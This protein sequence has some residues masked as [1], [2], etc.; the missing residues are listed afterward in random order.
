MKKVF[1]VIFEVGNEQKVTCETH[2][3]G[4]GKANEKGLFFSDILQKIRNIER[5][6]YVPIVSHEFIQV[7]RHINIIL[8]TFDTLRK[9][10]KN[11]GISFHIRLSSIVR[12]IA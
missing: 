9:G 1:I 6:K 3:K 7:M 12:M 4:Y 5:R 8:S 11:E 2:E 10:G